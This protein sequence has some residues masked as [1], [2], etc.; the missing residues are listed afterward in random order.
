MKQSYKQIPRK[1]RTLDCWCLL[2]GKN[3]FHTEFAKKIVKI[4]LTKAPKVLQ[5]VNNVPTKGRF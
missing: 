5:I 4:H 1:R 3:Y 2:V